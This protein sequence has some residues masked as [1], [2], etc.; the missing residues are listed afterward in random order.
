MF[1]AGEHHNCRQFDIAC[2]II[3]IVVYAEQFSLVALLMI[4]ESDVYVKCHRVNESVQRC[5]TYI[6]KTN[7]YYS[8]QKWMRGSSRLRNLHGCCKFKRADKKKNAK[9]ASLYMMMRELDKYV[10]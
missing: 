3:I 4:C 2:I 8:G 6:M 1:H 7:E 9:R 10:V 5:T